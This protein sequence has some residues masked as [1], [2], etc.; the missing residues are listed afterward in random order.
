[1]AAIFCPKCGEK[2]EHEDESTGKAVGGVG[3]AAAGAMLGAKVGIAAGPLGAIAG[4]VPGAIIGAV[5]GLGAGSIYDQAECPA[6]GYGFT[7]PPSTENSGK[8]GEAT[9]QR[10][11][12]EQAAHDMGQ[13]INDAATRVTSLAG[14]FWDGLWGN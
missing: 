14:A 2:F 11:S 1:M 8:N 3:G 10:S 5:G 6:C 7:A 12:A 13:T 4:T 9:M